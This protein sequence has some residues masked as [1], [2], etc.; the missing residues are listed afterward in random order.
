VAEDQPSS[1]EEQTMGLLRLALLL[2]DL[3]YERDLSVY[4]MMVGEIEEV[5]QTQW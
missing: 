2:V 4:V 5:V 1:K 3:P